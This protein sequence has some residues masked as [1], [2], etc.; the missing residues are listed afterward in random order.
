MTQPTDRDQEIFS[1]V[2]AFIDV[3]NRL[4]EEG[5]HP[6]LVNSAL[7]LASANYA[8]Y[9]TAGNQGYL[10]ESGIRKVAEAYRHNLELF[11]RIKQAE[12]E[13]DDNG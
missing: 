7:M 1:M 13:A 9:L 11:Q 2:Q 12:L 6:S 10:K 8:T 3:A 4:K 5:H